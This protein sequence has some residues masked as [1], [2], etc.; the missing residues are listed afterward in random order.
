MTVLINSISNPMQIGVYD[1]DKCLE[2]IE[3]NEQTS[4]ILLPTIEYLLAKYH[5]DAFI[6]V[7]GPGS[8]MAIKLT[9]ITLRTIE[10]LKKIPFYSCNAFELNDQSPLKAMGK[11][12]FIKEKETIITKRFEE[13]IEQHFKLPDNLYKLVLT[14]SNLPDY[15]LPVI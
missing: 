13:A 7:N 5:I 8:Y 15:V 6:Y 11:L 3:K 1:K 10:M 4:D 12:Y 14:N 9:Y 2:K